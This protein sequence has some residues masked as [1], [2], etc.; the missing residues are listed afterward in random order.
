MVIYLDC[1]CTL[2]DGPNAERTRDVANLIYLIKLPWLIVGDFNCTPTEAATS[3]W[4]RYLRGMVTAPDVPFTCTNT[5]TEGGSLIDFTMH[6]RELEPYIKIKS[7]LD[8]PLSPM[9]WRS[10]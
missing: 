3:N 5:G 7:I 8:L 1:N 2:D 9:S 6:C 10:G 4:C